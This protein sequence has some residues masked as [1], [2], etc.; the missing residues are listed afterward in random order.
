MCNP[1]IQCYDRPMVDPRE[2]EHFPLF[3]GCSKDERSS[4]ART[5]HPLAF[6]GGQVIY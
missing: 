5:L 2:L 6:S 3:A 1:A 4:L